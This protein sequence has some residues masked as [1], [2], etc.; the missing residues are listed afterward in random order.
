MTVVDRNGNQRSEVQ[1]I[2]T[3]FGIGNSGCVSLIYLYGWRGDSLNGAFVDL[4]K[5]ITEVRIGYDYGDCEKPWEFGPAD[6]SGAQPIIAFWR[7]YNHAGS[8]CP[9]YE[10]WISHIWA[11]QSYQRFSEGVVP[12]GYS[13]SLKCAV[14]WAN[15]AGGL[16]DETIALLATALQNWSKD[17]DEQYGPA[18]QDFFRFKLGV[19]YARRGQNEL[20]RAELQRVRDHPANPEFDAASQM[21]RVYLATYPSKGTDA[22]CQAV[23]EIIDERFAGTPP[24]GLTYD[25]EFAKNK[26]GFVDYS[27]KYGPQFV[28]EPEWAT[29]WPWIGNAKNYLPEMTPQDQEIAHIEKLLFQTGD[30]SQGL[31]RL[32]NLLDDP[33]IEPYHSSFEEP[34]RIKLYLLYLLGLAYEL[35]GDEH[36]AV[37]TYWQLW[38][39]YPDSPYTLIARRKL[40]AV[41]P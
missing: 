4:A 31:Q 10:R 34:P 38:R 24:G 35:S 40:A 7:I 11:G 17:I 5:D 20:A 33:I 18:A 14:G 8:E 41:G 6:A 9:P 3:S 2:E 15:W 25:L 21:A 22:A 1:V 19:W 12:F 27:W 23:Q 30:V 28:C 13:G 32:L 37:K 39:D 36:N 29:P 16:S 26:I